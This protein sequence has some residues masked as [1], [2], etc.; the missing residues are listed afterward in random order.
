MSKKV[1]FKFVPKQS[2]DLNNGDY[3]PDRVVFY[4]VATFPCSKNNGYH[5][6]RFT[7]NGQGS[8]ISVSFKYLPE[9]EYIKFIQNTKLHKY[10]KYSTFDLGEIGY[11]SAGDITL[12]RS[13][14][15]N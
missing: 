6:R 7:V 9:K 15:L 5:V 11:P 14:I 13:D 12:A 10:K 3:V 8:Y 1:S 2:S 4:Q